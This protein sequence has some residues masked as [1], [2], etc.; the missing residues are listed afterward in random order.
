MSAWATS[1]T[2]VNAPS[3][4]NAAKLRSRSHPA[5]V[6]PSANHEAGEGVLQLPEA[7]PVLDLLVP[8]HRLQPRLGH[9]PRGLLVLDGVQERLHLDEAE[10]LL[11]GEHG[12]GGRRQRRD[13]R[14]LYGLSRAVSLRHRMR[15]SIARAR[16]SLRLSRHPDQG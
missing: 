5:Q 12:A 10:H 1:A 2:G 11:Q 16:G 6:E 8:G 3:L 14:K 15:A 4:A 13:S 7:A 9:R